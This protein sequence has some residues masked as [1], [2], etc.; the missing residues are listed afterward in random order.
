MKKKLLNAQVLKIIM[1]QVAA[2]IIFIPIIDNVSIKASYKYRKIH[3]F[4]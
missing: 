4:D 1:N 2:G 3:L